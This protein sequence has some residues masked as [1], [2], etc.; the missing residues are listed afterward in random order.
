MVGELE[1]IDFDAFF[2]SK[3]YS[4]KDSH[5]ETFIEQKYTRT[6]RMR[7]LT[8]IPPTKESKKKNR[9]FS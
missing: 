8:F 7:D 1:G 6:T 2:N 9:S 5:I 4:H 3:K